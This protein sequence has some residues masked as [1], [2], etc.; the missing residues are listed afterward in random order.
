[1]ADGS[2]INSMWNIFDKLS[3]IFYNYENQNPK[4]NL[5][6]N[7]SCEGPLLKDMMAPKHSLLNL[8][9]SLEAACILQ[10]FIPHYRKS[11][12]HP[13]AFLQILYLILQYLRVLFTMFCTS[14]RKVKKVKIYFMIYESEPMFH[15]FFLSFLRPKADRPTPKHMRQ[16]TTWRVLH[17]VERR[18]HNHD[19]NRQ[20]LTY[21]SNH[22]KWNTEQGEPIATLNNPM[23]RANQPIH[24]FL[25]GC[26]NFCLQGTNLRVSSPNHN[27][28]SVGGN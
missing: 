19:L 10:V 1:M 8:P 5:V 17:R 22:V 23:V 26:L 28:M 6:A 14:T 2:L 12:F 24:S 11:K 3:V 4:L 15:F 25:V 18:F 27:L 9:Y 16:L 13:L 7:L 21:V 20:P